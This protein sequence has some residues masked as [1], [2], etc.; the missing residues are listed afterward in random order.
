M[1][2]RPEVEP[3]AAEGIMRMISRPEVEPGASL[4]HRGRCRRTGMILNVRKE[5][6][7]CRNLIG[8]VSSW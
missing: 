2:H 6:M 1:V 8:G 3:I 4:L 5:K 7:R